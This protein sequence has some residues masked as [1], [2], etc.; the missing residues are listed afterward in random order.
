MYIIFIPWVFILVAFL[1]AFMIGVTAVEFL[2]AAVPVV[3]VIIE[4]LILVFSILKPLSNGEEYWLKRLINYLLFSVPN[5]AVFIYM[6]SVIEGSL[7]SGGLGWILDMFAW[8]V[9]LV[10][11]GILWLCSALNPSLIESDISDM[12]FSTGN[13]FGFV[14]LIGHLMICAFFVL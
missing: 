1:I 14:G 5:T 6:F 7:Y 13:I 2:C 3:L 9:Y 10:I 8:I 12:S 4:V 11:G